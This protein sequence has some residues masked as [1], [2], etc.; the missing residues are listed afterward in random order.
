MAQQPD[1]IYDQWW[2]RDDL[3]YRDGQLHLAG[4]NLAELA[5]SAGTPVYAYSAGRVA[6]NL[7]RL[8]AAL[9]R[10]GVRHKIFYALK[11]N[12]FLPLLTYLKLTGNC[13][14]D[15]CS[16]GELRLARQVGFREE[17]ITYT[18]TSVSNDDLEVLQRH[19]QV[20]VNCDS[21]STIRRLG[22]RCPGRTIGLR[23]NP[24]LGA[25]YHPALR[26]A[27]EKATKFGL[28]QDRFEEALSLA[29][30]YDLQIKTLHFHC[31]SGY[32]T[33]DLDTFAEILARTNWYLDRCPTI[34]TLDI[35]GGLGLPL[36]ESHQPLDLDHWA[37][38]IA[39]HA[40]A[41]NLDIQLEPGD[42]LVKD[43][44]VLILEVNTVEEK[45]GVMFV[46]VNGGFNLQ[47]LAVYYDMPFIIAPLVV[48]GPA[49][50]QQLTIAG[51]INEAIDLLAED[52]FLP[53]LKE[54]DLL[55]L[56]NAGGYGSASSS[57][58]CMRGTFSEYLLL[59][60]ISI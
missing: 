53:P 3:H 14:L 35:G 6:A 18:N 41:R 25:G 32:L 59:D 13:G 52:I 33:P 12:R 48:D 54:G 10:H 26:Y 23:I 49:P 39:G 37:G 29:R 58:H 38:I 46:G 44:G 4:Q 5:H 40:Q 45:G 47:N 57:N 7:A 28:Y 22:E 21:L 30:S 9:T 17:E 16:P 11:A 51:N 50:L 27:G 20:W 34:D 56:L 36:V 43:A 15:V 42:Y 60:I 8:V 24:Q 31:G 55:A 1:N 2:A 19:P